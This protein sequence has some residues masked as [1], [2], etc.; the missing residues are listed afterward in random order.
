MRGTETAGRALLVLG[1]GLLLLRGHA[2]LFS[3]WEE[4]GDEE[5]GGPGRAN[6][7]CSSDN[8]VI[9]GDIAISP[10]EFVHSS[11]DHTPLWNEESD[12]DTFDGRT[13]FHND[14]LDAAKK[15]PGKSRPTRA[16][17]SLPERLWPNATVPY[18]ISE[19][20]DSNLIRLIRQ[21]MDH[22]EQHTCIRFTEHS[23]EKDY[24][25]FAIGKCGCCSFVGRRGNGRQKVS[26]SPH[27]ALFGVIVHELGHVI[28]FWHEHSRP[29]RDKYIKILKSNIRK[30]KHENFDRKS[31][32]EIDS[33]GQEYDYYSIMHYP[34]QTFSMNGR[35]TIFPLQDG[36]TIGQRERLSQGDVIQARVL[37][38]CPKSNCKQNITTHKGTIKTPLFPYNYPKRENCDWTVWAPPGHGIRLEFVEFQLEDS[39]NCSFDYLE[40]FHGTDDGEAKLQGRYCG[41]A[42]PTEV[43]SL[44]PFVQLHFQSDES[45][46]GKGFKVNY[47]VYELDPFSF[48]E[49]SGQMLHSGSGDDPMMMEK[50]KYLPS[51]GGVLSAREG[52]ITSPGFPYSYYNDIQC[53]W[54]IKG[55]EGESIS[56]TF[57]D[58]NLDCDSE[59]NYVQVEEL[60]VNITQYVSYLLNHSD[61]GSYADCNTTCSMVVGR[62]CRVMPYVI[63]TEVDQLLVTYSSNSNNIGS[64][65]GFHA[66]YT[67]DLDECVQNQSSCGQMCINMQPGFRCDCER[68]YALADNGRD[69]TP[70]EKQVSVA[71]GGLLTAARG[72]IKFTIVPHAITDCIWVVSAE[73]GHRIFLTFEEFHV[74][75][76]EDFSCSDNYLEVTTGKQKDNRSGEISNI[77]ERIARFSPEG[78][79][80]RYCGDWKPPPYVTTGS[81]SIQLRLHVTSQNSVDW[82][83]LSV[84]YASYKKSEERCYF[85]LTDP[86]SG[87]F[88]S[89]GYPN[90]YAEDISCV[91]KIS[92]PRHHRIRLKFIDLDVE[93]T[94]DCEYDFVAVHDGRHR[95]SPVIGQFCGPEPPRAITSTGRHLLIMFL[96]DKSKSGRGF[97][98]EYTTTLKHRGSR[99]QR[100]RYSEL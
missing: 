76:F 89:P 70:K 23:R 61:N 93:P 83:A 87:A 46:V 71:C 4:E 15:K 9:E 22:W 12:R 54:I 10:E 36:V 13:F 75:S 33:L 8:V 11:S 98:A 26:I 90:G 17:T 65:T 92:V 53:A 56:L 49:S 57:H 95:G 41:H 25:H 51:C 28:G 78:N 40:I 21:A 27:C 63:V 5:E 2:S 88:T 60:Y 100:S 52:N 3:E 55:S 97:R 43:Y 73:K 96:T 86:N 64:F 35:D 50:E 16:V 6:D 82:P 30:E 85:R 14:T 79:G 48:L 32:Y 39:R 94:V 80:G 91:W 69:C 29:D 7:P 66:S 72:G 99:S 18:T 19:K 1:L 47:T 31:V 81:G 68:G 62:Y 44:G 77:P 59:F 42:V 20:F 45:V 58:I 24:I 84:T 37:Y 38:N 74:N 67:V 34:K